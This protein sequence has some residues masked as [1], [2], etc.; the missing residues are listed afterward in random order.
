MGFA[1]QRLGSAQ[2]YSRRFHHSCG[3]FNTD[4]SK[5]LKSEIENYWK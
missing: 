1:L 3:V 2:S 5:F 4:Q